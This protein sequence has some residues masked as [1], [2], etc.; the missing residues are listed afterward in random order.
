MRV[1]WAVAA[2]WLCA[3]SGNG[4]LA[5]VD[6]GGPDGGPG[7]FTLADLDF[8]EV[9]GRATHRVWFSNPDE[10]FLQSVTVGPVQAPFSVSP[11]GRISIPPGGARSL[12]LSFA[13][14]DG[15]VHLSS[16]FFT[17]GEGC[18]P[19]PVA[20]RGL[21][22][23]V[24]TVPQRLDFGAVPL[25]EPTTRTL[26]LTSSRR[27]LTELRLTL[28]DTSGAFSLPRPEVL[29]APSS[30]EIL[31]LSVT[32]RAAGG[33]AAQLQLIDGVATRTIF[34]TARGGIPSGVAPPSVE[35]DVP[36]WAA[37]SPW[38]A[39]EVVLRNEGTGI[40]HLAAG[41]EPVQIDAGPGAV[42]EELDVDRRA[43]TN[44]LAPDASVALRLVARP[45]AQPFVGSRTWTVTLGV[46]QPTPIT[47]DVRARFYE[48]DSDC[49][50]LHF[51][52][53]LHLPPADAGTV[54]TT[55]IVFSYDG[56]GRCDVDDLRLETE[57][58]WRLQG[59]TRISLDA[60]AAFPVTVEVTANGGPQ[61]GLL[62]YRPLEPRSSVAATSLAIS[63]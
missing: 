19:Q 38:G 20:L 37:E 46:A 26:Q 28:V 5:G 9:D 31:E 27:V 43:L 22:A 8:G 10:R 34:L 54:V 14:E 61:Y 17:G 55:Q 21:G 18:T 56:G 23:G 53:V 3:C 62:R 7:C 42:A 60:G 40:L 35:L 57:D 63:P 4:L 11:S 24:I 47:F 30:V 49:Q 32:P 29:L 45:R 44:G 39:G 2:A 59:P 1:L 6:A 13:P 25:G 48:T 50:G 51:P 33:Y 12:D 36:V 52:S 15:L 41:V 16:F 58:T